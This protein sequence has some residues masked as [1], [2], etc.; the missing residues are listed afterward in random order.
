[1]IIT[2]S[3]STVAKTA[4]PTQPPPEPTQLEIEEN[5]PPPSDSS[6]EQKTGVSVDYIYTTNLIT[7]LYPLYGKNLDDFV[8]ITITNS[9]PDPIQAIVKTEIIGYTTTSSDTVTVDPNQSLTVDQN[10]QL[11]PAVIDDLNTEKP[12]QFHI[13]VTQLVN[14][15][16]KILLDETADTLVYARRDFPW[17]I[18]GFT[19]EEDFNLMA[20]MVTPNDPSVEDLLRK[21]ANY[22]DSGT[23]WNGYGDHVNDDDG[24]VYQRLKAIWEAEDRDFQLTYVSTWISYAPGS[25]QRIRLPAEVLS[26]HSGNC[27]ETSL[28][29]AAAVEA[30]DMEP[31][32]IGIPGHAF[33]AVREDGTNAQYYAIETT[34]IGRA[35]FA[36]AINRGSQEFADAMQHLQNK[37]ADYGWVNIKDARDKGILPLPWH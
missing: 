17:S 33:V 14:G 6:T 22:T 21:A 28:L 13:H 5:T 25:V 15:D 1:L 19:D 31:A 34:L 12:A 24:S 2:M 9:T 11:I 23:I 20:A 8:H 10:P 26:Q 3:C 29:F 7:I 36:E 30:L 4:A 37:D 27:I 16:E 18:P 32:I 35:S